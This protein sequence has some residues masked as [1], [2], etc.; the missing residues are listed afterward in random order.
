MS[1]NID[2]KTLKGLIDVAAGKQAADLVIRG[3]LI[4]DVYSGVFVEGDLAV[5]AGR[6]AALGKKGGYEGR[7]TVDAAGQYVLPGFI[8][9]HIHIESS[10][11]SP[12][13][14][15]RL[16]LPLGTAAIIADPHE[17][18]NVR[19][20]AGLDYM[21]KASEGL[22]LDIKFMVPSCVPA[23]P[24]E[25]AG[26]VLDAKALESPM[27]NER[28]LGLGEMMDYP[29]VIRGDEKVLDKIL[30][31]LEKNKFIDGHSPGLGGRELNAYMA[32]FIHTDH[33]CST[34]EELKERL[35]RGMYVMLRQGSACHDLRNLIPAVTAENS[36]RC[37]LCSDDCQPRTILEE[38]HIDK[39]LRI[40]VE[41][42]LDPM[43]ALRMATLNPA[44]CFGLSDRGGFAPG[45][46]ADMVLVNNLKEFKASRVFIRGVLAA[47]DGSTLLSL[48]KAGDRA[49]RGSMRV[50]GFS[51]AR[52]ALPLESEEVW[53]I[54][55]KSGTVLTG[56]GRAVVKRDESGLFQFD[57]SLDMAK[58]AVVERHKN[59]GNLGLGLI[60]GYGIRRGAVALSVAHDSH[61]II[62][63]G[64]SDADMAAAVEH[65]IAIG[66]GAALA[67]D[68]KILEDLPLPL[69][70]LM[71]DKSGEW[72]A[73]KLAS[74]EKTAVEE[75]G[76]KRD[77]EPLM[78]LCFMSLL[79]IPELKVSD[80]GLFDGK[81]FKFIPI[82]VPQ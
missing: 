62:C 61:N 23:T 10:F 9:S 37:L 67:K 64:A 6:I 73:A 15:A 77:L 55:M 1:K 28:I 5:F 65:L 49:V 2:K 22:P 58:I 71:S 52:L 13:E 66:G 80:R 8:D 20:L 47:R 75:L 36:R 76:V 19:G 56:K 54:D 18:V 34:P 43:T 33:E 60:R 30:L 21:L 35:A 74:L 3:G 72:V 70:G 27:E 63:A 42:G 25:H 44:E 51:R 29:G 53:V 68:G 59:T 17:L 82:E 41:E 78:G 26:A 45:K 40:C 39:D 48:P 11:L 79:V 57:P 14:L 31:A 69:G 4:A 12:S 81:E 16:I 46:K 32:G 50:K 7:E 38:G 24:F